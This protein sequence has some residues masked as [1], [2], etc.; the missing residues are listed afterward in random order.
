MLSLSSTCA[1]AFVLQLRKIAENFS[2]RS[3]KAPPTIRAV[4]LAASLQLVWTGLPTFSR[5]YFKT[6]DEDGQ[7][8]LGANTFQAAERRFPAPAYLI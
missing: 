1:L 8:S 5:H 3:W 7:S 2:Q 6:S 4:G